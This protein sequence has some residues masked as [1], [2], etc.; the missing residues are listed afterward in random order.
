MKRI[1][2]ALAIMSSV[3]AYQVEVDIPLSVKVK[4]VASY[5][6]QCAEA[7]GAKF[8]TEA[9]CNTYC[10]GGCSKVKVDGGRGPVPV[11]GG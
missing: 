3:V 7:E 5:M 4:T 11:T 2:I 8:G 1:L 6:W 9:H 10:K